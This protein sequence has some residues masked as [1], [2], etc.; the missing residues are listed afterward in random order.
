MFF[1]LR[2]Y[3]IHTVY[4]GDQNNLQFP[5]FQGQC[6]VLFEVILTVFQHISW[7]KYILKHSMKT[8]KWEIWPKNIENTFRYLWHLVLISLIIWH[9]LFNWQHVVWREENWSKPFIWVRWE[10]LCSAS[11]W[12]KTEPKLCKDVSERWRKCHGLADVFCSRSWA[13]YI[14]TW[15]HVYP[16]QS[17][18]CRR[19]R[20]KIGP[21]SYQSSVRDYSDV[22]WP[23][24]CWTHSKQ[25][26]SD[27]CNIQKL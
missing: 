8:F 12:G 5:T 25:L 2:N 11:N 9:T 27:C 22:L 19:D 21:R 6:L 18:T 20:K 13:T 7:V 14:A 23:Q 15:L 24:M 3:Y 26:I 1:L 4:S 10:T 16:L 17:P